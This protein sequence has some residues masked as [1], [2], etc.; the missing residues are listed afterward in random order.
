[1]ATT[2]GQ[3]VGKI[4]EMGDDPSTV[5]CLFQP[6]PKEV[7]HPGWQQESCGEPVFCMATELPMREFDGGYGS[8]EGE[9]AIG[10]SPRYVYIKVQYDGSE[11]V[12]AVPRHPEHVKRPIPWPGGG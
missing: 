7:C 9:P 2:R 10:F 12:D 4:K 3:F 8:P 6:V 11:W 1:M 5:E